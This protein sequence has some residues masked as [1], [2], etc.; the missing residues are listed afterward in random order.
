MGWIL[1]PVNFLWFCLAPVSLGQ[2]AFRGFLIQHDVDPSGVPLSISTAVAAHAH[3]VISILAA[4]GQLEN[5]KGKLAEMAAYTRHLE[6]C[7]LVTKAIAHREIDAETAQ[8]RHP[9]L[10]QILSGRQ[11]A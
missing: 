4:T 6:Y 8:Q 9:K 1:F 10:A 11:P 2:R 3:H 5:G 7:A